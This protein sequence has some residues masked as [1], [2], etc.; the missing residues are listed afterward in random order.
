MGFDCQTNESKKN[1]CYIKIYL[2]DTNKAVERFQT[3][4]SKK[5][6]C[7]IKIYLSDTNKAVERFFFEKRVSIPIYM[8]QPS[9]TTW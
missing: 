2:S 7:Y 1:L 6:L 8:T 5:N 3:N 4:E 9:T